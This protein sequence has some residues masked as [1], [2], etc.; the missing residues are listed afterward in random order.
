M[1]FNGNLK[2][3]FRD[4]KLKVIK[5]EIKFEVDNSRFISNK[6]IKFIKKQLPGDIISGSLALS[7]FGLLDR[8]P[9]DV[10]ILIKDKERYDFYYSN[11]DY[12]SNK[13]TNRLGYRRL[14]HKSSFFSRKE[15]LVDFFIDFGSTFIEY[16]GVK[17][18]N[19]IEVINFKM[20]LIDSG[21]NNF[22]HRRDLIKIFGY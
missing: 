18:Q 2:S 10:D 5:D 12:G 21:D 13:I 11:Y 15:Y 14:K 3:E 22:K 16:D 9:N 1:S 4:Y 8:E 19:P 20:S 17:I 6:T 7:L